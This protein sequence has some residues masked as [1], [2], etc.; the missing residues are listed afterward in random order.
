LAEIAAVNKSIYL[1]T[2]S[3]WSLLLMP[4]VCWW[5]LSVY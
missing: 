4:E 2:V 5:C 1:L 3:N